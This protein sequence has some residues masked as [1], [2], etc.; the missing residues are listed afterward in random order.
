LA[1]CP[2]CGKEVSEDFG[3]CPYCATPLK[4]FCPSCKRELRAGYVACPYC[5]FRLEPGTPAK[6]LYRKAGK[7]LFLRALIVL[8]F[9]GGLIDAIQGANESTFQF[10]NYTYQ[11]PIPDV[12]RYLAL[13]QVSLGI[14]VIVV[15]IVEFFIVP[16]LIYGRAFSRRY[17]LKMASLSFLLS[18]LILFIDAS[19]STVF[20]LPS[21]T[22]SFDIFFAVWT[23]L[24]LAVTYR[25]VSQQETREILRATAASQVPDGR[26]FP[27]E[28]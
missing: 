13:L 7:S 23:F 4:P 28:E 25:Y 22:F 10:A 16:G 14:L 21:A 27:A 6:R 5:G 11:G 17:L 18:V 20:S 2:S 12:A 9:V 26:L 8:T 19:I 1:T 24:L 15:G 3:Y